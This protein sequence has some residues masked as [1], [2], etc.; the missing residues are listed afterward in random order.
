MSLAGVIWVLNPFHLES[1]CYIFDSFTM[2]LSVFCS[3]FAFFITSL[4]LQYD[5]SNFQ[6]KYAYGLVII[7]LIAS[8]STYQAA[9][10]IYIVSFSFYALFQMIQQSNIEKSIRTIILSISLLFFSLLFYL[11]IKNIFLTNEYILS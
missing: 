9:I 1:F 2:S 3:I 11:P 8:L 6:L 10:S 4:I 7:L 5:L